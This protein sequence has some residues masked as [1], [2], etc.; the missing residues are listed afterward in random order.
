MSSLIPQAHCYGLVTLL[1]KV[2]IDAFLVEEELAS[3]E[4]GAKLLFAVY[5]GVIII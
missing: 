3:S 4:L 2:D 1:V 5:F